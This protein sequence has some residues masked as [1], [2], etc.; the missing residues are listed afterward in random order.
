MSTSRANYIK[1]I[2]RIV[3]QPAWELRELTKLWDGAERKLRRKREKLLRCLPS[4]DPM[5]L[6]VDLLHSIKCASDET[7]HTQA[8]AYILDPSQKHGFGTSVLTALL[9]TIA[10]INGRAGAA[11]IL[12]FTRRRTS[13]LRVTPEYRYRIE[14]YRDRS[15]ARSDIWVETKARKKSSV[16]VI[17]NK[18]GAAESYGQ[19]AWYERKVQSWCK[20][21]GHNRHLLVFLTPDGRPAS[22]S[23]KQKWI[24]LS[25]L[26]LAAALRTAWIAN[27]NAAGAEWLALYIASI[28][29][30]VLGIDV[31]RPEGFSASKIE[32]YLGRHG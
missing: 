31:D 19:L 30:S 11:R 23:K 2:G 26:Q 32:T 9:E 20:A 10:A 8:L 3:H 1:E 18:I 28:T 17:E 15:I 12:H 6:K 16:L 25:Y 24:A 29:Q 21:R 14:G 7:L 13:Q 5:H 22:T 4:D 27:R